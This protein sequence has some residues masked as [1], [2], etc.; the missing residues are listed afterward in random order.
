MGTFMNTV[1]PVFVGFFYDYFGPKVTNMAATA[2]FS[3]SCVLFSVSLL[4]GIV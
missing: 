4:Y 2:L 3:F 1:A